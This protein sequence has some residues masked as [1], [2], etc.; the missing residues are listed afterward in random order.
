MK[1]TV[2]LLLLAFT[3]TSIAQTVEVNGKRI[4]SYDDIEVYLLTRD[5]ST[6]QATFVDT[7][8]N[9][10]K[11]RNQDATKKQRVM[12]DGKKMKPGNYFKFKKYLKAN[13]W[14]KEDVRTT[15]LGNLE[16][17]IHTYSK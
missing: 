2:L 3:F 12:W 7:G 1:K 5:F 15:S 10:F 8:D 14:I 9:N 16:V 6:K 17:T 13:G 11:L 4:N